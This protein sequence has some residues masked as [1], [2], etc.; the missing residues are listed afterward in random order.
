MTEILEGVLIVT[1][2]VVIT[3][4]WVAKFICEVEERKEK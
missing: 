3:A 1:S 2:M 4:M